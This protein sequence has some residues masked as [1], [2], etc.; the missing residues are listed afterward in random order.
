MK[1]Y[2][3][4]IQTT[5]GHIGWEHSFEMASDN[6]AMEYAKRHATDFLG[7]QWFDA[8]ALFDMSDPRYGFMASYHIAKPQVVERRG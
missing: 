2:R 8:I 6:M 1:E 4:V 3:M 7:V 5:A